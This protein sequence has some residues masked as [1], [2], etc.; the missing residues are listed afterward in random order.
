[1]K[2]ESINRKF[3][4]LAGWILRYRLF[5]AGVFT[6]IV[7]LSF[8]GAKRIVMKTSFDD[9]FVSGDSIL[10]KTNEFKSIFGNDYYVAVLVKNKDIFSKRSLTLIRELSNE[11]KDSLSYADKVTSLTDLEF[12]V[13]TEDGMPIEQIVPDEIPSDKAA[14]NAIRQK[15]Y[16][17]PEMAKKLVSHDGKMTWIVVK[18][19]PFP[20]DSVW[21][22]TS[23]I[24]P[25]MLTGKEAGHIIGKAKYAELSPNAAGMPYMGYEK[26]VYLQSE[27]MR[28]LAFA[29][30]VSI[31]VMLIVT[32]SLRGVLAPLLTSACALLIGFGI[33]GWLGLYIDMST[34]MIAVILTFACSIA[35]NI[36][37]YNFF[38]TRFVETGKRRLSIAEAMGETGWGVLLSGL[39]TVAAMMTFLS[40]EIVPMKAIG[41]NTS[42]CLLAVLCTCLFVTPIV[43][44]LGKD[45]KP[46]PNM[47][48][49]FEGYIGDR[50][51]QFGRFV[52]RNH[53]VIILSSVALTVFCGIG[54]CFVEP[55]FDLE[56]T[57]GRK[58]P[59]VKRFLDLSNTEL[60]SMYAYDLMITLPHDNDAKK[61]EN[62]KKLDKLGSIVDGYKLTKRHNSITD[63]V[64]DMNCT[65]NG[66]DPRFYR[67]PD[68][69]DM[70][71]QLL[72]LY[73]NAGGTESEYWMDYDY[74]RLRLQ[75]ELNNYNSHEAEREMRVLQ[76]EARRLFPG[77]QVSAVGSLPQFTAMEGYVVRGQ[78]WSML[79]SVLVIGIILVL[80]F[81][82]WKVGLVGMIP[83]IAPA[84]IVGGMMGWLGYPLD[85]MT[86]SLIPMVLGIAVDD[87]IH[88][89]NHCHV[90]FDRCGDYTTAIN[91]TFRTEGLAIVMS[92]VIISATFAGFIPSEAAQMY[93]W[94]V[95]AVLGM[96]S[97]LLADLFLT[98]ILLRYLR[99]FGKDKT[100]IINIQNNK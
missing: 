97:A 24:A 42:L 47:S 89:I 25:D 4:K 19:R 34:A 9:Y 50:F 27:M 74:R 92:T 66:N 69:A 44:S 95:L 90:A 3:R 63:I 82:N 13:G 79:L 15:A 7:V 60:G 6:G 5:V 81:G 72:L 54:L 23:D 83:N 93:K 39:T 55:A 45:R 37:L 14:L 98:P 1:M 16:S 49:S 28:L 86:A 96:V 78:M 36:H 75:L 38:K 21:K 58:V 59:Y 22:K 53:R 40:M 31:V 77:A 99:V 11:L 8:V 94:G 52:L 84:I 2:I 26:F 10:R 71:A 43:L 88:F 32:R 57:I 41:I 64:K 33:I 68:R 51:A 67:I 62:L 73:E 100:S 87:T 18:L 76:T 80:I 17:K 61:P 30:I 85:M 91:R 46:T 12:T 65:L 56:K 48:R 35:Y 20:E 70:V 29:F